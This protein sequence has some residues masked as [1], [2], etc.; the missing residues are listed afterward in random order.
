MQNRFNQTVDFETNKT[1]KVAESI[2]LQRMIYVYLECLGTLLYGV[3][4]K[5]FQ[6]F[7]RGGGCKS[8]ESAEK[9]L[10]T[11]TFN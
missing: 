11:K 6:T 7:I 10:L 3:Q 1:N 8:E 4:A 2:P 5:T 9:V